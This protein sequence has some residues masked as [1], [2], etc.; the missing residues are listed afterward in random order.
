MARQVNEEELM[1][2]ARA[3]RLEFN[4]V[5]AENAAMRAELE[6]ADAAYVEGVNSIYEPGSE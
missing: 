5:K 6:A 3:F 1:N 2:K 4:N